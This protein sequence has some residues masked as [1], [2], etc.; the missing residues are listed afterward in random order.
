[1]NAPT[2]TLP[3]TR[4]IDQGQT[5]GDPF[6]ARDESLSL[7]DALALTE[8]MISLPEAELLYGLARDCDA[9]CIIE[10]G[11]Y[12]GRST[13]ALAL[14]SLGGGGAPVFAIEPHEPFDGVLGGVFGP[15][16]RGAFYQEMLA[17]GAY[18][19]VRLVNLSSEAVAPS[20]KQPVGILWIDGDHRYEGVRR[21]FDAWVWHLTPD[22]TV[23]F[24]DATDPDLG[25]ARLVRELCATGRWQITATVGKV[26]ALT[27]PR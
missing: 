19:P 23:L 6:L 22:A 7:A 13:V 9:A 27:R 2:F 4:R 25:P 15:Q 26:V 16:D 18:H 12:R 14:G 8:G 11:S 21:D 5:T 24:D 3:A 17:T 20:W 1:M 10:V